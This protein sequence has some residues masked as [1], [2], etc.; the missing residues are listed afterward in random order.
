M[1]KTT[2]FSMLFI[3][4][5]VGILI[6]PTGANALD[7]TLSQAD[8]LNLAE[9]DDDP[10]TCCTFGGPVAS[11][12]GVEITQS[13]DSSLGVPTQERLGVSGGTLPLTDL[14]AFLNYGLIVTNTD[15][16][17]WNYRLWIV[18]GTVGTPDLTLGSTNETV[19]A[20]TAIATD[21]TVTLLLDLAGLT[22][23]TDIEGIGIDIKVASFGGGNDCDQIICGGETKITP[24]PEPATVLLLG[25]GL[26]GLV[27]AGRIRRRRRRLA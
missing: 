4:V 19:S 22:N 6:A 12:D 25:S 3:G 20:Y 26:L 9:L 5:L 2:L 21:N 16:D 17:L 1:R 10:A 18:S 8:L 11:G 15:D 23:I 27:G 24:L 7:F 14:S 13:H